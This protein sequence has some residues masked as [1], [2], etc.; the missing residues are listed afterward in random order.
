M[1]SYPVKENYIGLAISEILRY[2]QANILL[3][4]YKHL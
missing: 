1:S 4:Y 2:T 3:F